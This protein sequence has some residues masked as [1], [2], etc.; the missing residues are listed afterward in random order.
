MEEA[1]KIALKE[2][3]KE[4]PD[5]REPVNIVGL[6]AP[7]IGPEGGLLWNPEDER[8][9]VAMDPAPEVNIPWSIKNL[10]FQC[11]QWN[12][13]FFY[14]M[15]KQQAVHTHCHTCYKVVVAPRNFRELW[16]LECYQLN[17]GLRCKCGVEYRDQVSRDYG[18]YFYSWEPGDYVPNGDGTW[19][20]HQ[21]EALRKG[22]LK[23]KLVSEAVEEL[24]WDRETFDSPPVVV[25]KKG[26][27]EFEAA[28]KN[29]NMLGYNQI[30]KRQ[31]EVEAELAR[32]S[33]HLNGKLIRPQDETFRRNVYWNWC[34]FAHSRADMTYLEYTG[35]IAAQNIAV[36]YAGNTQPDANYPEDFPFVPVTEKEVEAKVKASKVLSEQGEET[37]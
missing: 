2:I 9:E 8:I 27:T 12:R 15:A 5:L 14:T 30:T 17:C 23:T 36:T 31:M 20:V 7:V 32:V 26:C 18:G 29:T 37:S 28:L 11:F 25:L 3:I 6:L 1:A 13:L 19:H 24:V 34:L 35:G 21:G 22:Q 10:D 16:A 4:K 33:D